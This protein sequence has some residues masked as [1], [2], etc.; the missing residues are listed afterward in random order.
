M[1]NDDLFV[2]TPEICHTTCTMRHTHRSV[3]PMHLLHYDTE[4]NSDDN[5]DKRP[6]E[7]AMLEFTRPTDI[8]ALIEKQR[9]LAADLQILR[10]VIKRLRVERARNAS[11]SKRWKEPPMRAPAETHSIRRAAS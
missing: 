3:K 1:L 11:R 5:G 9:E 4:A 6:T 7:L 8:E 10:G 2:R